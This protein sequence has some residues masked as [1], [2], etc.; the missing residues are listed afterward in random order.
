MHPLRAEADELTRV[1]IGAAI[2]VHRA[3]GPGLLESIYEK[4]LRYEL[5][6]RGCFV[7]VQQGVQ[8]KYKEICF[9]ETLKY[10]LLVNRCVLVEVKAVEQVLP[11]HKAQVISYLKLLNTPVGLL[12]NFHEL[13][14]V[15]GTHRL[16]LPNTE[17]NN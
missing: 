12:V 4:C 1:I 16:Y 11:I 6:L 3:L 17:L 13:K 7:E 10:D 5:E 2:E 9:E 8:V 14:V 15:D